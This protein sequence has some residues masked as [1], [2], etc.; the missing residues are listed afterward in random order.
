V[1]VVTAQLIRPDI[2]VNPN[3]PDP[4]EIICATA[5]GTTGRVKAYTFANGGL[6]VIANFA[7]F[8]PNY[9]GG[10]A[11]AAGDVAGD[12]SGAP[13]TNQSETV[14]GQQTGGSTVKI[15]TNDQSSSTPHFVLIRQFQAFEDGYTGGVSLAAANIHPQQNTPTD[16][17]NYDYA[18]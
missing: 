12:R 2:T 17:Y 18:E 15:Y 14:V 8:G 5:G 6:Q 3:T 11:V 1:Y 4:L 13:L 10:I 7:P 16:P 9:D